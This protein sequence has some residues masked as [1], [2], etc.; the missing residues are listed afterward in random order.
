M[1]IPGCIETYS[2]EEY[3]AA[4]GDP[5]VYS[6]WERKEDE[7]TK[8]NKFFWAGIDRI[9]FQNDFDKEE[10]FILTEYDCDVDEFEPDDLAYCRVQ[11]RYGYQLPYP[12]NYLPWPE[13]WVN[14]FVNYVVSDTVLKKTVTVRKFKLEKG[15]NLKGEGGNV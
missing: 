5:T 3:I 13:R 11:K 14:N 7:N 15:F 8:Y 4:G 2:K 12:N 10:E 6:E 1:K 9:K